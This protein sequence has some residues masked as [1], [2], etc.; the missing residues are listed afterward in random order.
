MAAA[1]VAPIKAAADTWLLPA[2]QW[3]APPRQQGLGQDAAAHHRGHAPART[4]AVL[5]TRAARLA[6]STRPFAGDHPGPADQ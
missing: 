5:A 3:G 6:A 4:L 1:V 2:S